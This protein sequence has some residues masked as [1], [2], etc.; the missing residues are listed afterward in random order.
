MRQKPATNANFKNPSLSPLHP[1]P[2]FSTPTQ[3]RFLTA[4]ALQDMK[5]NLPSF[6]G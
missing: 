3:L 2:S 5:V 6:P 1:P 4:L